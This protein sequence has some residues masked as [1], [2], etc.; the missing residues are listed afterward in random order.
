[1]SAVFLAILCFVIAGLCLTGFI[2]T[3]SPVMAGL[4]VI[5]VG[6]ALVNLVTYRNSAS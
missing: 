1:M 4:V 5:N 2:I 3:N 6:L